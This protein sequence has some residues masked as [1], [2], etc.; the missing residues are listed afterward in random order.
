MTREEIDA[1][2]MELLEEKLGIVGIKPP[3][4]PEDQ[5]NAAPDRLTNT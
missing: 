3:N 1:K 4:F 5:A 2:I